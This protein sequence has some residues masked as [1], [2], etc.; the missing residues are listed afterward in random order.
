M[1]NRG[2]SILEILI[3]CAIL[4]LLAAIAIPTYMNSQN[5]AKQSKTI[6]NMRT[7]ATAWEARAAEVKAYNAAGVNYSIPTV[8]VTSAQLGTTLAP[9][10]IKQVPTTDGWGYLLDF[11][12]DA[13]IGAKAPASTYSIRS[14]GRDG[15]LEAT[16]KRSYRIQA[17][18]NFDCDI[19]YSNGNFIAYPQGK[20]NNK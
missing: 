5:R 6:E 20:Q 12:L 4:G 8:N 2:F 3:V 13:A 7:I 1:K 19:V 14:M 17:T 9:T 10:Y 16:G 18:T 11:K 15:K